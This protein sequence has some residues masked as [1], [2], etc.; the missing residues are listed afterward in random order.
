MM[1]V[2]TFRAG[3]AAAGFTA[4]GGLQGEHHGLFGKQLNRIRNEQID[5][6]LQQQVSIKEKQHDMGEKKEYEHAI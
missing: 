4:A 6:I 1:P 3:S 2:R 5:H